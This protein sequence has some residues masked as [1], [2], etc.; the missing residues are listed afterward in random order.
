MIADKELWAC[1]QT[2]LDQHGTRTPVFVAER[3][4][5]LALQDDQAGIETWKA[6]AARID[7]LMGEDGLRQ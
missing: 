3:I 7:R 6:I 5:A 2:V 4:G 1:A